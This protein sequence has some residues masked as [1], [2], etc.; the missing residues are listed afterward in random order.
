LRTPAPT[1]GCLPRFPVLARGSPRLRPAL[2]D[3]LAFPFT[4]AR[5]LD[6]GAVHQQIQRGG[7]GPVGQLHP[8][9]LLAP[10]HGAEVG[11]APVK[12]RQAQH[13]LNQTQALTQD[14]A[15]QA[16]DAQTKRDDCLREDQL[17]TLLAAGRWPLAGAYHC[18]SLYSQIV[19]DPRA[20]SAALYSAQVVL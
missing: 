6:P 15:E 11:H 13:T 18:M 5:E 14:Q 19:N 12:A 10:A 2:N 9:R 3:R 8:Q 16:L 1:P 4:F 17:A 7:A 20:L